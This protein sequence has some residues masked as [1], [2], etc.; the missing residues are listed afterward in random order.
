MKI[1]SLT[2]NKRNGAGL[3]NTIEAARTSTTANTTF[4]N[5]VNFLTEGITSKRGR[6][7][8]FK[9]SHPRQVASVNHSGKRGGSKRSTRGGKSRNQYGNSKP[10]SKGKLF[11]CEGKTLYPDMNYPSN[12][13]NALS[14]GE[15]DALKRAHHSRK[16]YKEDDKM[17]ASQLT[18]D[19]IT[20]ISDAII[21]G[22]K[23]AQNDNE[24][25]QHSTASSSGATSIT[26]QFKRHRDE[27]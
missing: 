10:S 25:E 14:K 7:E 1:M 15:K 26:S 5:Y 2:A 22:V 3:E 27:S 6:A 4:D 18:T 11:Q 23:R 12:E 8:T 19:S 17:V 9:I 20:Q 13:Y 21:A 16:L 24:S